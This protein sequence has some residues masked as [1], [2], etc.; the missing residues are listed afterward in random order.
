M[1]SERVVRDDY[2]TSFTLM[3]TTWKFEIQNEDWKN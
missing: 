3:N 1:I 2:Y